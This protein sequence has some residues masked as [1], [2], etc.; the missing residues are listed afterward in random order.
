MSIGS[1]P[2]DH[3]F[4]AVLMGNIC[5]CKLMYPLLLTRRDSLLGYTIVS[6]GRVLGSYTCSRAL[7]AQGLVGTFLIEGDLP[8]IEGSLHR[9]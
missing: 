2:T 4:R 9:L 7:H 1:N 8:Y 5:P 6:G 3:P